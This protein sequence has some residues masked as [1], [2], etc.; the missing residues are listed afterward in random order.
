MNRELP[1]GARLL[2]GLVTAARDDHPDTDLFRRTRARLG[3]VSG[4]VVSLVAEEAAARIAS[5]S[6]VPPGVATTAADTAADAASVV[7]SGASLGQGAA[8]T[9]PVVAGAPSAASMALLAAKWAC[10][11]LVSGGLVL[12]G[13]N[14]MAPASHAPAPSSSTGREPTLVRA[15]PHT[16]HRSVL[17]SPPP[18]SAEPTTSGNTAVPRSS[19]VAARSEAP[20][21]AS[22]SQAP[23]IREQVQAI[24]SQAPSIRE[25]VQAIERAR[26]A[27][28]NGSLAEAERLA[29]RYLRQHPGGAFVPEAL[30]LIMESRLQNRDTVGAKRIARELAAGYPQSAQAAK[31]MEVLAS[32]EGDLRRDVRTL[33]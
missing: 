15:A 8:S 19:E 10:L 6:G 14:A 32:E 9:M 28:L 24:P 13:I 26:S 2:E 29:R 11:S 31:A 5:G 17:A 23:S 1:S 3:L 30:Y 25:Q 12:S 22:P 20:R 16:A 21:G 27:A 18:A 7:S 33:D 4:T